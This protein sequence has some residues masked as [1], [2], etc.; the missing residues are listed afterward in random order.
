[1]GLL[2]RIREHFHKTGELD[3]HRG[4]VNTAA[5][6]VNDDNVI[7][8]WITACGFNGPY[9][10]RIWPSI[11]DPKPGDLYCAFSGGYRGI[12]LDNSYLLTDDGQCVLRSEL[13][14]GYYVCPL[15]GAWHAMGF[16]NAPRMD[17]LHSE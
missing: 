6:Y 12:V 9:S 2:A 16:S 5:A 17:R 15:N 13:E 11:D 8:K 3:W 14:Q 4:L 1:M 10:N 7:Q